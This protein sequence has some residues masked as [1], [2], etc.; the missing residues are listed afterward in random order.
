MF[1]SPWY[2]GSVGVANFTATTFGAL[3]CN[4]ALSGFFTCVYAKCSRAERCQLWDDLLRLQSTHETL[5]WAVGG[6]FNVV[7]SLDESS[8]PNPPDLGAMNDFSG[9]LSQSGLC[10]LPTIG[11]T[12][13]WT[14]VRSRGRVWKRL[15][16]ILFTPAWLSLFSGS[17][18]ELLGRLTSDHNP[19]LLRSAASISAPKSF[20][21]QNMWLRRQDFLDVVRVYLTG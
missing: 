21:F 9:F 17:S 15:D 18:V 3:S 8:G 14:G 2:S 11:G 12:Y 4:F 5:P 16:R 7:A 1:C 6:D 10:D 13:T 20:R 19:L